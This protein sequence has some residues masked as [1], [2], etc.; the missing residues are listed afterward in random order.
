MEALSAVSV[1]VGALA[2]QVC[3]ADAGY[4]QNTFSNIYL[5]QEW[6]RLLDNLTTLAT[7]YQAVGEANIR[8]AD[9]PLNSEGSALPITI[10]PPNPIN[11]VMYFGCTVMDR[12]I[13]RHR[14]QY[15]IKT[16]NAQSTADFPTYG[17]TPTYSTFTDVGS[18][19]AE[20]AKNSNIPIDTSN[21]TFTVT[22][23][24][25]DINTPV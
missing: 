19:L 12:Q 8:V 10:K 5:F 21:E 4:I 25:D 17:S 2:K 6:G 7:V 24:T 15:S 16:K 1:M 3:R 14:L 13:R 22:Q 20:L 18:V 23:Y 9:F 11:L